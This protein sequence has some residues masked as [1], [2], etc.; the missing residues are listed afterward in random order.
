MRTRILL[1]LLFLVLILILILVLV[2]VLFLFL[3]TAAL[4]NRAGLQSCSSRNAILLAIL[5]SRIAILLEQECDPARNFAVSAAAV[6]SPSPRV[7]LFFYGPHMHNPNSYGGSC[8][9]S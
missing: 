7:R 5:P 8:S 2:L 9:G 6:T 3:S 1:R 4:G